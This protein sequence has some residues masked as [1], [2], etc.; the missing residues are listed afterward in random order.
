[1]MKPA[2]PTRAPNQ[3]SRTPETL[4][5]GDRFSTH[6]SHGTRAA[7]ALLEKNR[8]RALQRLPPKPLSVPPRAS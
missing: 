8:A 3:P 7:A 2:R 6:V 1:M 5:T 4:N